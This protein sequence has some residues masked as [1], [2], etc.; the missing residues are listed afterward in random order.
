MGLKARRVQPQLITVL[1]K[2]AP[3]QLHVDI[4][5]TL[6]K[7]CGVRRVALPKAGF[8]EILERSRHHSAS[9]CAQL[10]SQIGLFELLRI[11]KLLK[12]RSCQL[13]GQVHLSMG[14]I[15]ELE[16]KRMS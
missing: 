13:R 2:M 3:S 5:N 10:G 4:L 8:L 14:S 12:H 15:V 7:M 16:G 1:Q 11:T 6:F 9:R